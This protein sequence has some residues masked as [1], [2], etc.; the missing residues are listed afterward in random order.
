M[1]TVTW[2]RSIP[3]RVRPAT[4]FGDS[5]LP[6]RSGVPPQP[7]SL[8]TVSVAPGFRIKLAALSSSLLG[9]FVRLICITT[10]P[11]TDTAPPTVKMPKV[12][13]KVPWAAMPGAKLPPACT[14]TVPPMLPM[15]PSVE[16]VNT[17]ALVPAVGPLTNSVPVA[18]VVLPV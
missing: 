9:E 3:D 14:V 6:D 18:T 2:A 10:V 8:V 16:L 11:D 5:V 15:P 12:L 17:V 7:S 1:S 4:T 13:V